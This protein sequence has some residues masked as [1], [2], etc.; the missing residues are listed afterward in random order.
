L[1]TAI[2]AW[3][4][5]TD[6]A[7]IPG[8]TVTIK[9]GAGQTVRTIP[10]P[11][12]PPFVVWDGKHTD[13]TIQPPGA[14][15]ATLSAA[16]QADQTVPI[17]L[18]RQVSTG[19]VYDRLSRLTRA[20]SPNGPQSYIYDPVG[21][22][23]SRFSETATTAYAYDK[24]D[25]ITSAGYSVNANGN[26]TVRPS[27]TFAYDQANRLTNATISGM[28]TS[29]V[30]DGDG[31][32]K[33]KSGGATTNY[34]YDVNGSL[35]VILEDGTRKYVWGLGLAYAVNG[36][37]IEVHQTDGLG[38][39]R[40]VTDGSVNVIQT[41]LTDEFGVSKLTLGT[42]SQPFHYAGEPRDAESGLMYL[43]ARMYEPAL[44]RFLQRDPFAGFL[45]GPGSLNRYSYVENSPTNATDPSGEN[46]LLAACAVGAAIGVATDVG[47]GWL[48][49]D[50]ITGSQVLRSA[51]TG[52]LTGLTGFGV[53]RFA[54]FFIP[55]ARAVTPAWV[56]AE[57]RVSQLIGV[58]RNV[59]SPL[60]RVNGTGLGGFRV[61]DFDPNIT[62]AVRGSIVEVKNVQRLY[63]TPQLR[64]LADEASKRR[65]FL[66]IFT[67]APAPARGDLADLIRENIVRLRPIP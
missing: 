30:Y 54:H 16:G 26:L 12:G 33:S 64:D 21:N 28:P 37:A 20:D 19:Y 47:M 9:N 48:N 14:Y 63:I 15:T 34:T 23:L 67:N 57:Q 1:Q 24:A 2:V 3:K 58:P 55:A 5:A 60:S 46:P 18:T 41:Y 66:E 39:V 4:S 13:D 53:V 49:G 61:P 35:P 59:A 10:A 62:M 52:C 27:G 45:D 51:T 11:A 6:T 40:A 44:G 38:S 7:Q 42:N 50:K 36:S 17:S 56:I 8:Y 65:G 32:R 31:K 29:Y 22:R 25:R 43:R